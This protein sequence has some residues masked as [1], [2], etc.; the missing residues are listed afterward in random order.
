[1]T[2]IEEYHSWIFESLNI[3]ESRIELLHHGVEGLREAFKESQREIADFTSVIDE[4]YTGHE[5]RVARLR[6]T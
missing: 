4:Y 3:M 1:M 5:N 6:N 2:N